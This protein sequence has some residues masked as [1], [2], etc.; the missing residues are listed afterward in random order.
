MSFSAMAS[1]LAI[2]LPAETTLYVY[3]V[4]HAVLERFAAEFKG[5]RDVVICES[6][7]QVAE[8]SASRAFV[9]CSQGQ[10]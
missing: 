8:K 1:Q 5:K 9:L 7:R 2:K 4:S 3:D 6:A 10:Y